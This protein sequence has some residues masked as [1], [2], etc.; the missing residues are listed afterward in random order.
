MLAPGDDHPPRAHVVERA[1][2]ADRVGL[3]QDQGGLVGV[4]QEDVGLGQDGPELA[5]VVARPGRGHVEHGDRPRPPRPARTARRGR[6][7]RG[8]AGSGSRRRRGP[9]AGGSSSGVE[10][11]GREALVGAEGVDEAAVLPLHVDDQRLARGQR[12][13]RRRARRR[14]RRGRPAS[15]PRTGRRRRR[16]PCR[17]PP[18]R[19]PSR[20]RSIAAFEAQ[21]PMFRTSSSAMTSSPA[22]GRWSIGV[23]R[24]SAT[25][26][27]AQTTGAG[28]FA[29]SRGFT[30]RS[31]HS[32]FVDTLATSRPPRPVSGQSAG[33]RCGRSA[34][35]PPRPGPSRVHRGW[36][37][38][39][40]NR[41]GWGI[42]PKTRPVS[43][44]TP[45]AATGEPFGLAG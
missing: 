45:A 44:Q 39:S 33:R 21:P 38:G 6:R 36:W 16:R 20:A 7:R 42:R 11:G 27:P 13:G 34:A 30:G 29:G 31:S 22:A 23:Q 12:R 8:R 15:R 26:T 40:T 18:T 4:G 25:T 32:S 43:S 41:S 19:T 28:S 37:Y 5:Q 2:L 9:A 17:R 3:A 35:H 24:W 10:V 1:G 14:R